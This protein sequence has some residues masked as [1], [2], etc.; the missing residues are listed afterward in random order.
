MPRGRPPKTNPPPAATVLPLGPEGE[1]R[2]PSRATVAPD[3]SAETPLMKQYNAIKAKYPG[4]LLLFRMGDF[5]ETFGDDA[6][7]ASRILGIT[8]TRRANGAAADIELAGFPHHQIDAYLPRLVRAGQRVAVCD[9]LEDPKQ[10]K[11]IVKRGVTEIVT[12]GTALAD[13][14]LDRAQSNYLACLVR[15]ESGRVLGAAFLELSTAEFFCLEGP[16]QRVEKLL[17]AL[18]PAEVV[19]ARRDVRAIKDDYGDDFYLHR[20]EDWV[21]DAAFAH[22]RV[23][24]H[25]GLHSLKGL[26]LDDQPL[27]TVAA[28]VLLHY[29][30]LNEHHRLGHLTRLVPFADAQVMGLDRY[31]VRNLELVQPLHADGRALVDV[32]D[33]TLTPMG[34][35]L[36]RRRLLFPLTDAAEITRRL[37]AVASLVADGELLNSLSE[38]LRRLGDLE[39]MAARLATRRIGPRELGALRASLDHAAALWG[40]LHDGGPAPFAEAVRQAR[41]ADLSPLMHLL[42]TE[43]A[44]EPPATLAHGGVIR[45]GLSPELDE[46]RTLKADT[47]GYLRALREREALRTGI[48]SLKVQFNKVFGYYI[49][50]THAHRDR[51]PSD[52]IRKQ[53]LTG[54]ERYITPELKTFE[55]KMLTAEERIARLEAERWDDLLERLQPYLAPLQKQAAL[56]AAVDVAHGLARAALLN[57]YA[58]PE[59]VEAEG[60]DIE[61]GRH[62][63]IERLLP[64]E[65]PYVPN[66]LQLRADDAQILLIT[67][68]NMAG[69]S[70]LLR[71]TALIVILAQMGSYVPAL[72][73]RIGVVDK[74]FTRVGASDNLAAGESTFLVEMNETARILNTATARSLILLDEVGRGTA[75]YDGVSIA[76][77]LVEYLHE[78]A[79]V[80]AKTLFATHYHELA[81]LAERLPRVRNFHVAVKET[82]GR[83]IFLRKLLPGHAEHSFGIQVAEMAGLPRPLV[84]RARALLVHFEAEH[85]AALRAAAGSPTEVSRSQLS[86]FT[87]ADDTANRIRSL[88]QGVDVNRLTPIEAL[89]K[90]Q[91]I[92][93][94]LD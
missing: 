36:L 58:R 57:G 77:A 92:Q 12:P 11:G 62:P 76:W 61:A 71:Q 82:Q 73:A 52:Y 74:V 88:L 94:A 89:L 1:A 6:V 64:R 39:R 87:L 42:A 24:K 18:R 63:V 91:E 41:T 19:V 84:E 4:T 22:E 25:F 68:P 37:D 32:I 70:A 5:Y 47:E 55:E 53:T 50:I 54:A 93:Q 7:T 10:A 13:P 16:P 30:E 60:L 67:G 35:R 48:T 75:T 66:D 51:V 29:L 69:K 72:R 65:Q 46:L 2:T 38:R 83:V 90:L 45:A 78:F 28:G 31:T 23:L 44:D 15:D 20:L 9:Q 81:E 8:L 43:L 34:A 14:L 40:R 86:M 26:G 56:L 27:G 59:V 80:A 79:P 21:F 49:E 3:K 33:Q 85:G 17:Y